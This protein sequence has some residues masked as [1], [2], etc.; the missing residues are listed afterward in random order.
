MKDSLKQLAPISERRT[1]AYFSNRVQLADLIEWVLE[2]TGP[3]SLDISTF[4]T[5]ES[6]LRRLFRLKQ[7]GKVLNCR[8]IADVRA[9]KKTASLYTFMKSVCDAIF[10]CQNHSKVVLISPKGRNTP[11]GL[12]AIVT[13]QNQTRGDRYEAG[14]I[15][16]EPD[17]I[18]PL[19]LALDAMAQNSVSIDAILNRPDNP[20]T[21]RPTGERAHSTE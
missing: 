8:L 14:I 11:E 21:D 7:A 15:T 16:A 4:S 2:Q 6:F 18:F 9:A 19:M 12:V 3:A 5:S 20:G 1:Q 10:L 17:A 13:S